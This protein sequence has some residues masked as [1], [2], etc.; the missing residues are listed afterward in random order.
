MLNSEYENKQLAKQV[1][2]ITFLNAEYPDIIYFDS[3]KKEWRIRN[4]NIKISAISFYDFDNCT[5]GDNIR[6]LTDYLNLTFFESISKLLSSGVEIL[7]PEKFALET[8][9]NPNW[10]SN[11]DEIYDY[12]ENR[13]IDKEILYLLIQNKIFTY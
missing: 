13:N 10:T 1:N 4:R 8:F 6:F 11:T 5:G 12:L 2:L 7:T 3:K 9:I